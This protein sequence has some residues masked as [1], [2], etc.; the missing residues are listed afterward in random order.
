MRGSSEH[1]WGDLA[2]KLNTSGP[3]LNTSEGKLNTWP[4]IR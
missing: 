4:E 3:K 1:I 2:R